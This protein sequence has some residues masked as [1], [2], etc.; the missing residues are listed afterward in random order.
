VMCVLEA[1]KNSLPGI[2]DRFCIE[3][4]AGTAGQGG[5]IEQ[6]FIRKYI[7]Q[8]LPVFFITTGKNRGHRFDNLLVICFH[9][10]KSTIPG[11]S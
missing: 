9:N 1:G 6:Y 5:I 3:R 11:M 2:D 4:G 7:F 10:S 8:L